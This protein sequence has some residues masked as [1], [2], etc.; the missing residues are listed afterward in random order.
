VRRRPPVN[1]RPDDILPLFTFAAL[2]VGASPGL[3]QVSSDLNV[4]GE[5]VLSLVIN[6]S[7]KIIKV[8]IG[9]CR[10]I[11]FS[12][13]PFR[14]VTARF[15]TFTVRRLRRPTKHKRANMY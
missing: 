3:K 13:R 1:V 11:E 8:P 15:L 10:A 2:G 7:V 6:S 14:Y 5:T 9:C 12:G 4:S